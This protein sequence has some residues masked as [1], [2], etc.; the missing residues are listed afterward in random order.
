MK[1]LI[2][3]DLS[4][5]D[6]TNPYFESGDTDTLF[7][8]TLSLFQGNDVNFVNLECVLTDSDKMIRKFG[9]ALK[10]CKNTAKVIKSIG[11]DYCSLANNHIF[12]YGIKGM[13]DTFKALCDAGIKYTGFGNNYDDARENLVIEKNGEKVCFIAVCEHE[14]SYATDDRM[15]ARGYDEYDTI[16]DIRKAKEENDCVIVIYHGGKEHCRYPSP[17]LRK[18]CHAMVDNGADAVICQHSHCI[19]CYE[20]YNGKH[21][22]YGQGNFHFVKGVDGNPPESW[23]TLLAVKYD[24]VS[25]KIEFIPINNTDN[26]ITLAKGECKEKI[27]SEFEKRN[28]SLVDGTWRE[29]WHKFCKEMQKPY[30]SVIARALL[31]ENPELNRQRFAHYI[32]C[33]AHLDVFKELF[34]SWNNTNETGGKK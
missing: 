33:E 22:L 15:G 21:I 20:E 9:P 13:E 3:G 2:F 17:R 34:P 4:P 31:E 8:D 19:G 1:T 26:G 25:G 30:E 6:T 18:A 11:V 12:D 5:T 32:D 29:G 24:T 14:Y 28:K 27:I 16:E 23:N 10:A 7:T